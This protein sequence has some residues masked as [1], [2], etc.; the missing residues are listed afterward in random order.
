[1]SDPASTGNSDF[2]KAAADVKNLATKPNNEE[3]LQLYALF[4]QSISGD[5]TSACPGMFD[6]QGKAKWSA[7]EKVKGTSKEDAQAQYIALVKQLQGKN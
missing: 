7:W 3:L 6:L 4:K 2:I 1:M 5:N